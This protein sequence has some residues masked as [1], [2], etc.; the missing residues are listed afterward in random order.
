[1]CVWRL[2]HLKY[3]E[4]ITKKKKQNSILNTGLKGIWRGKKG[5][6][7]S[8]K[9]KK[10]ITIKE[11]S[12]VRPLQI[13]LCTHINHWERKKEKLQP[14]KNPHYITCTSLL[15]SFF[16]VGLERTKGLELFND[17]MPGK[18][19]TWGSILPPQRGF[20]SAVRECF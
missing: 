18:Y 3:H 14:K 12:G 16:K 9:K 11:L 15:F 7:V 20:N 1:M 17:I 4:G 6:S 10:R 5:T 2:K 19:C 8:K 13:F